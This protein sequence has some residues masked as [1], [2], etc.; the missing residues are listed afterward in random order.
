MKIL[1]LGKTGQ[2]GS[3]LQ[4]TLAPLGS[5]F[6]VGRLDEDDVRAD[7]SDPKSVLSVV[8]KIKPDVIVNAVAYTAVDHAE[9]E[10]DLAMRV[11]AEV[12][13]L[14]AQE[15][16][17]TGALLVHY[18]TDYV[19]NGDGSVPWAETDA[20]DPLSVYGQSKRQGELAIQESG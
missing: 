1:L 7:F 12:P 6:V 16:A 10:L 17:K 4:A 15:A 3:A 5:L 14:I 13:G 8:R 11:N 20:T 9:K 2:V 19:F 18:S